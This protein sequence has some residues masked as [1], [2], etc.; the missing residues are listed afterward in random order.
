MQ[1]NPFLYLIKQPN[2]SISCNQPTPTD[3][4]KQQIAKA[5]VDQYS[6]TYDAT[7][8]PHY[9]RFLLKNQ[10]D[11]FGRL[12]SPNN[13]LD[14][15][16]EG[17][18]YSG[19]LPIARSE[20]VYVKLITWARDASNVFE[21]TPT[22]NYQVER[23]MDIKGAKL[24]QRF[25]EAV[26]QT[27]IR[28][29]ISGTAGKVAI[30]LVND[31]SNPG[32]TYSSNAQ[33]GIIRLDNDSN[34]LQIMTNKTDTDKVIKGGTDASDDNDYQDVN[35]ARFDSVDKSTN[36][37]GELFT[38]MRSHY[39]LF[40]NSASSTVIPASS[41]VAINGIRRLMQMEAL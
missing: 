12:T 13:K 6:I 18:R 29:Y 1:W 23:G 10:Q 26:T 27:T 33:V 21:V 7:A 28:N 19:K 17:V 9:L 36:L 2:V 16:L 39:E 22:G 20:D 41:E 14:N 30:N 32:N 40:L 5:L 37:S 31:P 34:Q 3:R 24:H 35:I 25:N 15:A 11:T 38:P 4:L 8:P